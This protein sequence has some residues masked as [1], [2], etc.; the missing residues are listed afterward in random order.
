MLLTVS[1]T[2]R[3]ATDLGFLLHKHPE[4][5]QSFALPFGKAY[6]FY[7]E[8]SDAR[9]IAAL[10]L[11]LDPVT[12]VRGRADAGRTSGSVPGAPFRRRRVARRHLHAHGPAVL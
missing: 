4:R 7:P 8:A 3:P 1:T 5:L 9:C 11:D 12:L 10:M 6:V 2:H